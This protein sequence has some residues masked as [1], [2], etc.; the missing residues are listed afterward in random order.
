MGVIGLL[1]DLGIWIP[2]AAAA[3]RRLHDAGKS[4]WWIILPLVNLV[5]LTYP[6]QTEN[7]R[8]S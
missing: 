6:A 3:V 4:G 2:L 5:F 7:N 1:V 8:Y